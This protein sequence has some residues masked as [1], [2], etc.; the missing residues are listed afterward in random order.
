ML[1]RQ[2]G[3]DNGLLASPRSCYTAGDTQAALYLAAV[4]SAA[5]LDCNGAGGLFLSPHNKSLR[6]QIALEEMNIGALSL[7]PSSVRSLRLYSLSRQQGKPEE[8]PN[9]FFN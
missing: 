1:A 5:S 9:A 8:K 7:L 6:E 2:S 3:G 4:L